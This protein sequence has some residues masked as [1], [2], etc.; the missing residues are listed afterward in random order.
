MEKITK[1]LAIEA[2]GNIYLLPHTSSAALKSGL[3]V[4]MVMKLKRN[5]ANQVALGEAKQLIQPVGGWVG[6]QQ[7]TCIYNCRDTLSDQFDQ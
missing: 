5:V 7:N 1:G 6:T 3:C 2:L 4:V